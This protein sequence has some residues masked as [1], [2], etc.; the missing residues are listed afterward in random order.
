MGVCDNSNGYIHLNTEKDGAEFSRRYAEL[1][2]DYDE[3]E[4]QNPNWE[5]VALEHHYETLRR[6][7]AEDLQKKAS[8]KTFSSLLGRLFPIFGAFTK[9]LGCRFNLWRQ[10]RGGLRSE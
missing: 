7:D 3:W 10:R 2:R 4:Y 9:T 6:R 8:A 5:K 1:V